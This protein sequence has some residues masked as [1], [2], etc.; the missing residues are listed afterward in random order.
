MKTNQ[1]I[2][3][4]FL[5]LLLLVSS[6]PLAFA[7]TEDPIADESDVSLQASNS[8]GRVLSSAL[9]DEIE[10]GS[11]NAITALSIENKVAT[12]TLKTDTAA[13][14]VVAIYDESGLQMLASGKQAVAANDETATV[15]IE[16]DAM[17]QY[18]TA[19]AFL[20]DADYHALCEAYTSKDYT[21]AY[22]EFLEKTTD[23]FEQNLVVNFDDSED[24]NFAVLTEDSVIADTTD[25]TNALVSADDEELIYSFSNIDSSIRNLEKDDVFFYESEE[26]AIALKVDSVS[27]SGDTATIQAQADTELADVFDFVKIDATAEPDETVMDTAEFGEGV[28]Y[29]G[30]TQNTNPSPAP[31]RAPKKAEIDTGATTTW[32]YN[33]EVNWD[34]VTAGF[35]LSTAFEFKLYYDIVLFG[36]DYV[37]ASFSITNTSKWAITFKGAVNLLDFEKLY[38]VYLPEIPL[39]YGLTASFKVVPAL[40]ASAS[41]SASVSTYNKIGFTHKTGVGTKPIN[42]SSTE[43]QIEAAGKI[44]IFVGIKP[45]A[46][47]AFLKLA[48]AELSAKVGLEADGTATVPSLQEDDSIQHTCNLCIEGILNFLVELSAS[49]KLGTEKHYITPVKLTKTFKIKLG[50]FYLSHHQTENGNSTFEF[51]MGTCPYKK[52]RVTYTVLDELGNPVKGACVGDLTTNENGQAMEYLPSGRHGCYVTYGD[53]PDSE[54]FVE[55]HDAAVDFQI[56]LSNPI[57]DSNTIVET[58]S[59]GSNV[60]YTL[61]DNGVMIIS[62]TG[63]MNDA[64]YDYG[65]LRN[66]VIPQT[67]TRSIKTVIVQNGVTKIGNFAFDR[68]TNLKKISLAKSVETIGKGAF[69]KCSQLKTVVLPQGVKTVLDYAFEDCTSLESV[70]FPNSVETIGHVFDYCDSLK[71]INIPKNVKSIPLS[72]SIYSTYSSYYN[73]EE[74]SVDPNNTY[75]KS[76]DGVVFSKDGKKLY[77]YPAGN[78][79]TSYSVPDSVESIESSAFCHAV[80]LSSITF[81]DS[82]QHIGENA[83]LD[84]NCIDGRGAYYIGRVLY[85]YFAESS[86]PMVGLKVKDGTVEIASRAFDNVN[87]V[88]IDLPNSLKRIGSSAFSHCENLPSIDLPES[89]ESIEGS[90]FSSSGITQIVIPNSVTQFEA[91]VFSGCSRLEYVALSN[92][93]TSI[94]YGTFYE[95]SNLKNVI[96]PHSIERIETNAFENCG[97]ETICF[98]DNIN[99]IARDAIIDCR[100]LKDVYIYNHYCSIL[101]TREVTWTG[102]VYIYKAIHNGTIHGYTGSTAEV[103]AQTAGLPFVAI[104]A[105]APA[106][107]R[108]SP[109]RAAASRTATFDH[110]VKGE[111]YVFLAIKDKTADDLL[112]ADN[113][114]Y[115][116]QTTAGSSKVNFTYLPKDGVISLETMI[117]GMCS[118]NYISY[119]LSEATC[120]AEGEKMLVCE[121]C[122]NIEKQPIPVK[123]HAY[124]TAVT[125][126]TCT[127][128]GQT[129][130]TCPDCGDTY[131]EVIPAV[132]H[133]WG[134][135]V[136]V[137]EPSETEEGLAERV[138]SND[139]THKESKVLDKLEVQTEDPEE[140]QPDPNACK[141]CGQVHTGPFA[142]LI[143]FFHNILALFKR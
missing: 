61:Y 87:L 104:D 103:Y 24:N 11:T 59:C 15:T 35:E 117:L 64:Y 4:I 115:I 7:Q 29:L 14:V 72:N 122:G 114:L 124:E 123:P 127:E 90:A 77:F 98:D 81:P 106:P 118:H 128:D 107:A 42:E 74:I 20:L 76:I 86:N 126:A 130:Y 55:V 105:A 53:Y 89:I 6:V 8:L 132:G 34:H 37:E 135:W 13:T 66:P 96:I 99:Y 120:T 60:T 102:S 70:T 48:R 44:N 101:Y 67:I 111:Q 116:D 88:T 134:E 62:G 91:S 51:A 83:F 79:R 137:K 82:I 54:W 10:D 18:Y 109:A 133:A 129:V 45:I 16:A 100:N 131:T 43:K 65:T 73:L 113:L 49:L 5:V 112:S 78:N 9:N 63:E 138:C 84:T 25:N 21:Q 71:R 19:K 31:K 56:D 50:N 52:Y 12:V 1:R 3:S 40:E 85:R 58:G 26:M 38:L 139:S 121:Y 36:K 28:T 110:A 143:K 2:I 32:K 23:D 136:T 92:Q 68:C 119:T 75:L 33:F 94:P 47:V 69:Y 93:T 142:W 125:E 41:L 140:Q 57:G 39:G 46:T 97:L 17:P 30:A 80:K 27:I 22:E 95:C 141:Y 108:R